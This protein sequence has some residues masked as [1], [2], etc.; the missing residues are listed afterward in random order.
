VEG[1]NIPLSVGEGIK[2]SEECSLICDVIVNPKV[3]EEGNN[4]E[5]GQ[6]RDF[7]CQLGF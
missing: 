5:T 4:D 7:I 3:V 2:S 6:Y 1:L